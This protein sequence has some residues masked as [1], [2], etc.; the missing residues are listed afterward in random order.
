MSGKTRGYLSA[1]LFVVLSWHLLSLILDKP[2]FPQPF[3]VM[4]ELLFRT[5]H[6]NLPGH[7][8][9]SVYRVLASLIISFVLAVP[10]GLVVGRNPAL[11]R[12]VSPVIYLLYPLPKTVF[13]PLIV[14]LLGLGD[15]PKILLISLI[16]FFQILV[17]ARDAAKDIAPQWV[18]SMKSLHATRWQVYRHLVWP[19]CL[20]NIF[21]S[22][23]ISL[24]TAIAVLFLAETFASTDG[25]GYFILDTMEKREFAAMY[26]GILAMGLLGVA[27]YLLVDLLENRF[28]RWNRF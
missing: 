27:S 26:A 17:A 15:S 12:L 23:R 8:L 9:V 13:L 24:G 6:G 19:S 2:F 10:L 3:P 25:L 11:D 22:L 14:V 20:P 4:R 16:I 5:L 28:C 21:T 7:F 18:L 1:L